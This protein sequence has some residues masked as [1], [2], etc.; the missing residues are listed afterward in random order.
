[1]KQTITLKQVGQWSLLTILT[2]WGMLAFIVLVGEDNPEMPMSL[3]KF[4]LLKVGAL[5]NMGAVGVI[6]KWC[7]KR[8]WLP[9][10]EKLLRE[11]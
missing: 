7:N 6:A 2:I 10:L 4:M 8:S 11:E 3:T 5:V 9:N 1:M